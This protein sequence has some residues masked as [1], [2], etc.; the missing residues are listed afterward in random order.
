MSALFD[1]LPGQSAWLGTSPIDKRIDCSFGNRQR[2]DGG[3]PFFVNNGAW[4]GTL[5]L[6]DGLLHIIDGRGTRH[7]H[8]YLVELI[9]RQPGH[10]DPQTDDIPF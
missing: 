9:K 10:D 8:V 1:Q 4:P 3:M 2:P 5:Y 6:A 7:D